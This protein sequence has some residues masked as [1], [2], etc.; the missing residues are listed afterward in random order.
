MDFITIS[1]NKLA[2]FK[3]NGRGIAH[4]L[5]NPS[6]LVHSLLAVQEPRLQNQKKETK[7]SKFKIKKRE[8]EK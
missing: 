5:A 2:P 7:N 1:E 6:P 4:F 8:K 3:Q